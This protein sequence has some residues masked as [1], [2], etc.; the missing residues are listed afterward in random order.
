[1]KLLKKLFA[2]KPIARTREDLEQEE[3]EAIIDLLLIATY[4]DN[5]LSLAENKIL[6]EEF[7]KFSWEANI[8]LDLYLND[9]TNRARNA[10][11][12]DKTVEAYLETIS[13]RLSSRY[14]KSRA[15]D[16]LSKLF[17]SDGNVDSEKAFTLNVKRILEQKQ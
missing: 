7:D 12:S 6:N 8:S 17:Y 13:N 5:H 15:L 4:A 1:M 3:K 10:L 9:A 2:P 14:S 11:D 16:L